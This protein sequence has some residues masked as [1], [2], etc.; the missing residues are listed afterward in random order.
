MHDS[1]TRSHWSQIARQLAQP[2]LQA[3]SEDKLKASMPIEAAMHASERASVTHLEALG[4]M[5]VGLCPW[6]ERDE[7]ARDLAAL[8]PQAMSNALNPNARDCLNFEHGNQPL[9]DAAFLAQ[10]IIRAPDLLWHQLDDIARSRLIDA[11]RRTRAIRPGPNNW[12]L[13]AGMIEAFFAS[14]GE[15]YD[16]MRLDYAI[17]QHMQ[18]YKGDGVYGDGAD[19]HF[20]YYNSF[21]I[22]PMLLDVTREMA[23]HREDWNPLMDPIRTR[24][25]R[26]A[27]ILERMI[28]PD[29]SFPAVG[30]SLAYRCGAFYLLAQ[31]AWEKNLPAS[32]KPSQARCALD[33]VIRR[34][35]GS[36]GTFDQQGWLTIGLA[37]HQPGIG[38]A[39][40]STGSL[41]LCTTALLPL[42][43]DQT[44]SF[45]ADEP[46]AF[47]GQHLWSGG[48]ISEPDHALYG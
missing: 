11:F 21:V 33:A 35:L 1:S 34:T 13:F 5:L 36:Q 7:Q 30:R 17:R 37:G 32:I 22:Q 25:I 4:R 46:I 26:Y 23:K 31:L 27:Q 9:V 20:D 3:L 10:A 28:A 41:Y 14:V 15:P 48:Q 43:L 38:E 47:T 8:L 12:L 40:I 39:Y 45:W 24:A 16:V 18:W 29:G 2:I 42:G 44:E 19:F 6:L